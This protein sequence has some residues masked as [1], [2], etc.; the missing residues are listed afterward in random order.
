MGLFSRS[1]SATATPVLPSLD[2]VRAA[3]APAAGSIAPAAP[4]PSMRMNAAVPNA[5]GSG[6]TTAAIQ[7]ERQQ[8]M[9]QLKVK[10]H[11]KL[12]ERLDVQN[13]RALP[14]ETV[15]GEVRLLVRE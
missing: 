3:S 11:Q 9:N 4:N 15:R 10:I 8:Y 6:N 12:V 13:L 7:T 14:P 1:N 2:D 5:I